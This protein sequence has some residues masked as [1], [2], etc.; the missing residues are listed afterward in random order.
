MKTNNTKL[1]NLLEEPM[2][3]PNVDLKTF[4]YVVNVNVVWLGMFVYAGV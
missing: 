1:Y 3:D 4:L 2:F